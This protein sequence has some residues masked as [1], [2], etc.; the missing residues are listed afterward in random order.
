MVV[1]RTPIGGGGEVIVAYSIP[2]T[3]LL[4]LARVAELARHTQ[5]ALA[6]REIVTDRVL[7][8]LVLN[9]KEGYG[10]IRYRLVR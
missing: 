4:T 2:S 3:V 6:Q 10:R 9:G 5:E 8:V 7:P 1:Y